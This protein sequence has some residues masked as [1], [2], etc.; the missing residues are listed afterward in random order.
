MN[1]NKVLLATVS[2]ALLLGASYE[3]GF[4]APGHWHDNHGRRA[5]FVR[6]IIFV[7][8][9]KQFD[10]DHDSKITRD[11]AKAGIDKVFD[12]VDTNKDG[13]VTPGELRNYLEAQMQMRREQHE[14]MAQSD[15]GA[16][17]GANGDTASGNAQPA[18]AE[19]RERWMQRAV[20]M[21]VSMIIRRADTDENGQ[22]SKQEA[23]AAMNKLFDRMDTN[24]DGVI[25]IDD[26]P[27]HPFL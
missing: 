21:R 13:S 18:R 16:Q 26:M 20:A 17:P 5:E 12:V 27:D 22:V 24:K 1:R 2:A 8:M 25:S 11:E 7:R 9:L 10:T 14:N 23:E 4:A 3:T 15:N 6:E 19:A